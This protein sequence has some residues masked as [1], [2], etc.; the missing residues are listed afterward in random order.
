MQEGSAAVPPRLSQ[1]VSLW[2]AA[3]G[4]GEGPAAPLIAC[5]G[6]HSAED[7]VALLAAGASAV[8]VDSLAWVAPRVLNALLARD[9][10]KSN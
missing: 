10:G 6:V 8:M 2:G 7:V 3:A 5:G 4:T 1:P 9:F